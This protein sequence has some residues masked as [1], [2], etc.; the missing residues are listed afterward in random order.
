[1]P[2]KSNLRIAVI[3]AGPAGLAAAYDLRKAG[4]AVTLFEAGQRVGGLAAGFRDDGWDWELEK[5]YHHWFQSDKDILGLIDELG[6]RDK[7]LFPR[8]RTSMWSHGKPYLFDNP[9][10]MLLF[11]HI[12]LIPKLRDGLVSL[13]LRLTK[14][15]KPMER[16]TAEEWLIKYM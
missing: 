16:Y 9:L 8:P 7:V 2:S 6:L 11:P 12:P 3:G 15:W 14:N 13:Y 10:S 1:M 5:F 4:H